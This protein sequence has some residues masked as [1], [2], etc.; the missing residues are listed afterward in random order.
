[1]HGTTRKRGGGKPGLIVG[2]AL[3]LLGYILMLFDVSIFGLLSYFVIPM[4]ILLIGSVLICLYIPKKNWKIVFVGLLAAFMITGSPVYFTYTENESNH[5]AETGDMMTVRYD[6]PDSMSAEMVIKVPSDLLSS[7]SNSL[8]IRQNVGPDIFYT[9]NDPVIKKMAGKFSVLTASMSDHQRVDYV[10]KFVQSIGY[11]DDRVSYGIVD[12]WQFPLETVFIGHG[13]CEDH[14][15]LFLSLMGAMGYETV[16]IHQKGN[17]GY[18][19][20][21]GVRY[22]PSVA[23]YT[24]EH[25]GKSF[26]FCDPSGSLDAMYISSHSAG[27][28]NGFEIVKIVYPDSKDETNIFVAIWIML[29]TV[30]LCSMF[31]LRKN[32]RSK[33]SADDQMSENVVIDDDR[34]DHSTGEEGPE[35]GHDDSDRTDGEDA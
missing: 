10:L 9:P 34:E 16:L 31:M 2:V 3:L 32:K 7:Y 28:Y 15:F 4:I 24:V 19:M 30:L 25:D 6:L 21:V 5:T 22:T 23:S 26:V 1:V 14:A 18:H 27:K 11:I 12:H 20:A 29:L 13:D 33:V 8:V 35:Q 17:T